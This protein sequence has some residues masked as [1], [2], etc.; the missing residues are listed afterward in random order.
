MTITAVQAVLYVSLA[1]AA[2]AA[3]RASFSDGRF[4]AYCSAWP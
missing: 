1:V 4:A 3:L 2:G